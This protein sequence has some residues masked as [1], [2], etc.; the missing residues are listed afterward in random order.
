VTHVGDDGQ[1]QVTWEHI[2][3]DHLCHATVYD[4]VAGVTLPSVTPGILLQGTAK[5]PARGARR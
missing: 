4:L 5:I 2:G 1:E 3:P